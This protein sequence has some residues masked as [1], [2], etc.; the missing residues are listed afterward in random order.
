MARRPGH[1]IWAQML[2][3][4]MDSKRRAGFLVLADT[5]RWQNAVHTSCLHAHCIHLILRSHLVY[6]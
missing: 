2:R 5:V 1:R 4:H 6:E 3:H